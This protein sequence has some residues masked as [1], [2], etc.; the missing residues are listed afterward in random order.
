MRKVYVDRYQSNET[1]CYLLTGKVV[2]KRL[3][4]KL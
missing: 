2:K 3:G 4:T 1:I